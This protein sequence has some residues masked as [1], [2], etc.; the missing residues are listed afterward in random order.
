ML[1]H[2][3]CLEKGIGARRRKAREYWSGGMDGNIHICVIISVY[4]G[5]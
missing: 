5:R 4:N 2:Q 3:P 1:E